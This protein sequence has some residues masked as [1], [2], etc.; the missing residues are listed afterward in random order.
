MRLYQKLARPVH[1]LAESERYRLYRTERV[2]DKRALFA[3]AQSTGIYDYQA[4]AQKIDRL[5]DS[6]KTKS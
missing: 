4:L 3:V 1:G 2:L 6:N 5:T